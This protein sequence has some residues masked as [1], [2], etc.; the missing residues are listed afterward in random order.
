MCTRWSRVF[1]HTMRPS[2]LVSTRPPELQ[3]NRTGRRHMHR[4]KS[5]QDGQESHPVTAKLLALGWLSVA[6]SKAPA[7]QLLA[8]S[9]PMEVRASESITPTSCLT[10]LLHHQHC[11]WAPGA[12]SHAGPASGWGPPC[13][14]WLQQHGRATDYT[15]EASTTQSATLVHFIVCPHR[16]GLL[17]IRLQLV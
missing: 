15:S 14:T 13:H 9:M 10:H 3:R 4:V 1:R 8:S 6:C 11:S 16:M 5:N 17:C 12:G 2:A 7:V